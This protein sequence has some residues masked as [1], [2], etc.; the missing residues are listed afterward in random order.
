MPFY[1]NQPGVAVPM[2]PVSNPHDPPGPPGYAFG[3]KSQSQPTARFQIQKSA[4]ASNVVTLTVQMLEGFTPPVGALAYIYATLNDGGSLNNSSGVAIQ[5]ISLNASGFGTLTYNQTAGNLSVTAD[6]GYVLVP[7]VETPDVITGSSAKSQQFGVGGYGISWAYMWSSQPV[8]CSIQLEGA[9]NDIDAEYTLIGTA[10]TSVSGW[11]EIFASLP[12][13]V[14]FVR[15]HI[16]AVSGG[17]N[18]SIIAKL[19]LTRN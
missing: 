19:Q 18:P 14:N 8:S 6:V 2:L 17:T 4:V 7:V 10:Q 16:T 9:I 11:T 3:S 1:N 12:E 5:S 13:N 15:L